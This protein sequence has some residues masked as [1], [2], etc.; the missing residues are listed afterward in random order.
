MMPWPAAEAESKAVVT[1]SNIAVYGAVP[2][3]TKFMV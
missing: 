2:R 1:S 3:R